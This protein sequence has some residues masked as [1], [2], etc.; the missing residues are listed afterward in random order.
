MPP[1]LNPRSP[2]AALL[3]L[4]EAT[5]PAHAA[6][7]GMLPTGLDTRGTYQRYLRAMLALGEWQAATP[8]RHLP[9]AWQPWHD[10]RRIDCLRADLH[11]LAMEA[12]LDGRAGF[13]P[14]AAA[15]WIGASDVVEG[16]A[17]GGRPLLRQAE[18]LAND[19]PR[20]GDALSFLRQHTCDAR[21]WPRWIAML[22]GLDHAAMEQAVAG[23]RTGFALAHARLSGSA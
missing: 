4:R 7:D 15:E 17:L 23:A 16:S 9:A 3:R 18:A 21:R 2:P 11:A 20:V 22:D 1:A 14:M 8:A 6:L 13:G 12:D 19:D 5:G 10:S